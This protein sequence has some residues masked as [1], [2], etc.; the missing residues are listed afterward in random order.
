[1]KAFVTGGNGFI[2]SFLAEFLLEKGYEVCC[3]VRPTSNLQWVKDLPVRFV[4]GDLYDKD[5]LIDLVKK[6]EYVFHLAG[7]IKARHWD[8]YYMTNVTGTRNLAEACAEGN[9][10]LKRFVYVSS[11]AA[12]GPSGKGKLKDEEDA[13]SPVNEYGK[14]KLLGEDV[15]RSLGTRMP[16]VILRPPNVLGPRQEELYSIL[17]ILQSRVKLLL[18]NGDKQ[19]SICFIGDL[20]RGIE[21]AATSEHTVGKTYFITDGNTY[22]WREIADTIAEELGVSPFVIPVPYVLLLTIASLLG[23]VARLRGEKSFFD[24][25]TLK[26]IRTTY[27]TYDSSKASRD[28]GF[29]AR[30]DMATGIKRTVEWYTQRGLLRTPRGKRRI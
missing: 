15:V 9:S 11:I 22:S 30:T 12:S 24:A 27:L 8:D 28:F 16:F 17:K 1:M 3:L 6:Q 21:M 2:G 19:L 5:F 23:F 14:T 13:D 10:N 4:Y 7:K 25:S 29:S 18:G 26:R 20:V